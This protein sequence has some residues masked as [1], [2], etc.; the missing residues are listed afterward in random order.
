MKTTTAI[1]LSALGLVGL[2]SQ[3]AGANETV[4]RMFWN[5]LQSYEA[6]AIRDY[7]SNNVSPDVLHLSDNL[8]SL[9]HDAVISH[10]YGNCREAA[11]TLSLM[12]AGSYWSAK[13]NAVSTDWLQ[14]S[15][16]YLSH[17]KGCLDAL[18]YKEQDYRLP[19]WFGR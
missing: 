12:V 7:T 5:K 10:E 15:G 3:G 13:A 14:Y 17:R 19:W 9:S 4:A 16:D 2:L 8:W 6:E 1:V 18:Q 11:K